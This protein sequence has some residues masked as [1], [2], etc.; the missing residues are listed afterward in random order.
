MLEVLGAIDNDFESFDV[1]PDEMVEDGDTIVVLSQINAK[2]KSGT[3]SG[4][5]AQRSGG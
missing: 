3:N 4:R 5:R 2:S 1:S